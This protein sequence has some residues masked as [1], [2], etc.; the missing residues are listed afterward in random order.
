[1]GAEVSVVPR[2]HTHQKTQKG[3]RLQAINS[4]SI[5]TYGTC[6]LTL[7]LGFRRTFRWV[8]IIAD[9]SKAT[10]GADFLKHYGLSV[11][12]KSHRLL[13]PLT[14][15]KVQGVASLVASFLIL[16]LLLKQPKS[17]YQKMLMEFPTIT[18]PYDGNIQIRHDVSTILKPE[19]PAVCV[20]PRSLAPERLKVAKQ[21]FQHMLEL[22]IICPSLS[23]W[24]SPLHV[25]P[26]KTAWDWHSCGDYRALSNATI[27]NW[28]PIQHI[29]LD[30]L[31]A[32][33]MGMV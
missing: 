3:L 14:H 31:D 11:D 8:F 2:S 27:P 19:A 18:S 33:S 22:G 5:P 23:N 32:W 15:L 24:A 4:T 25:V 10:L 28:Y 21:E 9:I 7:N 17:D 6:L 26:K 13:D 12:M 16:S 29:L 30:M 1:M 20:K